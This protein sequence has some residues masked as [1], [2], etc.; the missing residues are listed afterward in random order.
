MEIIETP[1]IKKKKKRK[2]L[3]SMKK[4]QSEKI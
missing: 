2:I 3:S 1:V 4:F